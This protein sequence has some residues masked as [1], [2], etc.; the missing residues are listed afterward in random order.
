[1]RI[2]DRREG[3]ALRR[4][5]GMKPGARNGLGDRAVV[6]AAFQRLGDRHGRQGAGA[7]VYGRDG[8]V[9]QV[10]IDERPHGIMDQ[11]DGR[12][13]VGKRQ[14]A[15]PDGMLARRSALD[16]DEPIEM[17]AGRLA[18]QVRIVGMD[19][20]DDEADR[21]MGK[22]RLQRMG[23]DGAAADEPVLLRSVGLTG[24]FAPSGGNDDGGNLSPQLV[25]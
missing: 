2:E 7:L 23:D 15:E 16:D 10:C 17:L 13:V 8:A 18:Q 5:R 21:G 9:D 14:Q 20:R 11:H 1:M 25:V 6:R 3:E 22:E 4:L 24:A 19:D 12:R